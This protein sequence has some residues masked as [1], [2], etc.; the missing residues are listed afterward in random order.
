MATLIIRHK[1]KD[2]TTWKR[3]YDEAD[4]STIYS[5]VGGI[6]RSAGLNCIIAA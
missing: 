2:Y 3:G 4:F 5:N 6:C 1:V